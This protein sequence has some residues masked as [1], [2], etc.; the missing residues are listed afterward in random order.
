MPQSAVPSAAVIGAGPAGLMA[1]QEMARAGLAVTIFDRMPT[2]ARKFLLAGRGGLN[3]THSEPLDLFMTRYGAGAQHLR[4]HI[5]AFAPA[6]LR[7]WSAELGEPT[8]AGSSGRVFPKSFKAS[9][10][11]RALLRRLDALGVR[12]AALHSFSGFDESGRPI[13]QDEV[14]AHVAPDFGAY[15]FALGGAS[16][17]KLGSDARW[18]DAFA[19]RGLSVHP[20]Q[21][22]NCGFDVDWSEHF[23]SRFAG[24][25]LKSV[26]LSCGEHET[27]GEVMIAQS[28]VEGGGIYALSAPLRDMIAR[29]G[30]ASLQIDLRP[31]VSVDELAE[32]LSRPRGSQSLSN[33]LRKAAGLP[34]VA[35]AL[36]REVQR[37]LPDDAGALAALIKALPLPLLRPRP[38]AR[39]ISSAGGLA[40]SEIDE[41]LMLRQAPG[42]FVC[43]EML[44]WEAP[45]GG[46]LL[47]ACFA[48]GFVAGQAAARYAA[49]L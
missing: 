26:R 20:F 49:K 36:L 43:G 11:L 41:N 27:R 2:P 3:L 32:R 10:L 46:Y 25:P 47:Q 22:A 13:I 37:A 19:A 35:L 31:D 39:A 14:G 4:P 45:T 21:P 48:T 6:L 33:L 9:P 34:P 18:C 7:D 15:V 23:I 24:V 8:F 40:F 16:W 1:A 12:L 38:I 17:P 28:G 44:D 30:V 42:L 5:E 29:E